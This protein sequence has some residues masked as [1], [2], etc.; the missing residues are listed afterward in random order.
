MTMQILYSYRLSKFYEE[1]KLTL[2]FVFL[3]ITILF[4]TQMHAQDSNSFPNCGFD[5]AVQKAQTK[6]QLDE[7]L[8][9]ANSDVTRNYKFLESSELSGSIVFHVLYHHENQNIPDSVLE[10]QISILNRAS[11]LC[12]A[13]PRPSFHEIIGNPNVSFKIA[14]L[15][16]EINSKGIIRK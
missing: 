13:T 7:L 10:N 5:Q 9:S 14:T 16:A 6:N 1:L 11:Q 15:N 3:I 4:V 12:E 2:R 8:T